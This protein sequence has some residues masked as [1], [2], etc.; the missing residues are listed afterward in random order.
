[1]RQEVRAMLD[2][3][4]D[5][6]TREFHDP[7]KSWDYMIDFLAV[8]NCG[9]LLY[10]LNH[11]FEWLFENS[12]LVK[13]IKETYNHKLLKSEVY[14]HL[15][16]MYLEKIVSSQQAKKRGMF[17]T[18][19][20]VAD[21]M[22]EMTLLSDNKEPNV[23]DPAVGTGRLLMSAYKVSPKA[24][25]FGVDIDLRALRIAFTNFAIH[26]ITGYLLHANS[27]LHEIDIAE[28]GGMHNWQYANR[29]YSCMDKLKPA[30]RSQS[31]SSQ[32]GLWQKN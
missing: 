10:Q 12:R 23:L 30:T 13:E 24:R 5:L 22:A 4:Y 7:V 27:L 16:E 18:P 15:G 3:M 2:K 11:K 25:L 31:S 17:L 9:Q 1:M 8:D 28:E 20:N 21:M 6:F 32:L 29:W 14:D 26:N 19:M